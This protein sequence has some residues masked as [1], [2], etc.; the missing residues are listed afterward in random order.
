MLSPEQMATLYRY[1][2]AVLEKQ[3]V[4]ASKAWA[5]YRSAKPEQWCALLQSDTRALP[6]LDGAIIRQ[7]QEY[8]DC[9]NDRPGRR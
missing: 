9:R 6:Y 1:E 8:P 7:L 3:L 2:Q 5:A 4:L